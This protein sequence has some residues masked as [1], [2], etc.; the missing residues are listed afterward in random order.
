MIAAVRTWL[1]SIITVSMLLSVTQILIPEGTIRKI[2]SFTS[3]LILLVTLLQPVLGADL[4]RL[5]LHFRDYEAEIGIRQE[6]LAAEG[7]H[8]LKSIIE[9]RTAAYISDK[10]DALG[11][12]VFVRVK[13]EPGSD[14]IPLPVSADIK[15]PWS[16]A[17]AAYMERELGIPRERQVWHEG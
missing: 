12:R 1:I 8:E 7:A 15:G 3:G 4:R 9:T 5:D 13:S 17:L 11:L 10:A 16:E 2:A 6:E 14:G